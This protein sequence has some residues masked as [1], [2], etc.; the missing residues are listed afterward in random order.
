MRSDGRGFSIRPG[1]LSVAL[2]LI[3]SACLAR[4]EAPMPAP[5]EVELAGL[6][7]TWSQ[8]YYLQPDSAREP[9][10]QPVIAGAQALQEK[11][12]GRPE[13]LIMEA[14][15]RSAWAE[16]ASRLKA[17][18]QAK[19]AR[20][21]LEEA[22]ARDEQALEGA[23]WVTLG[24]LYYRVPG[25]PVGFGDD[26]KAREYL[27]KS[28]RMNPDNLDA[29]FFLGEFLEQEGEDARARE[30]WRRGLQT[31][32]RE[33]FPVAD[34]GRRKMIRDRLGGDSCC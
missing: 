24:A 34:A 10:M 14:V 21:L 2:A 11:F 9:G 26:D 19:I 27:E 17:L 13:P 6:Y 15:A 3:L 33:R 20:A 22:I 8:V 5:L 7:R 25:W 23:A 32:V 30:V 28:I 4:A 16:K 12:A 31:P 29:Y 1:I 18:E